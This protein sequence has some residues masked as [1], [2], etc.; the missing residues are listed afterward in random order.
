MVARPLR[1]GHRR[2]DRG[3]GDRDPRGSRRSALPRRHLRPGLL[4]R[5]AVQSSPLILPQSGRLTAGRPL[6]PLAKRRKRTQSEQADADVSALPSIAE[7]QLGR[8]TEA[9]AAADLYARH[10]QRIFGY[11]LG[12][13]RNREEAE[14]AVQT[15]F[16]NAYRG[17]RRG[18]RPEFEAAWLYKIAQNVCRTR[19]ETAW[20]RGKV[21]T[22]RDLDALQDLVAAPEQVTGQATALA[23]ALKQLPERY[24]TIILLR[25]WQGLSYREIATELD[26]SEAAVEMLVF[27]ARRS[28][29]E[30]L[31]QVDEPRTRALSVASL[32]SMLKSLFGGAGL[33]TAVAVVV[34]ATATAVA[35]STSDGG[36]A[37]PSRPTP[38]SPPSVHQNRAPGVPATNAA[39][40]PGRPLPPV[41]SASAGATQDAHPSGPVLPNPPHE[42]GA[43][44][45]PSPSGAT[46]PSSSTPPSV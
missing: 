30:Q 18:I 16:L 19:R 15:T 32:L 35:V 1:R 26:L 45:P 3:R 31:E 27:R 36:H 14:D 2:H 10:S 7:P 34:A 5:S 22:P 20:R 21:E 37:R 42:G 29:A 12:L 6:P 13:L 24:R 23:E 9:E 44:S 40:R 46:P 28:L 38:V 25:E 41:T 4:P 11:C 8:P 17:L 39:D 43:Q 33:K